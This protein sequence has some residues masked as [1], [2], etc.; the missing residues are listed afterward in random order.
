MNRKKNSNLLLGA[1]FACLCALGVS[2]CASLSEGECREADWY[3]IGLHDGQDGQPRSML[4]DHRKACAK[5]GIVPTTEA[6]YL[7]REVGLMDYCTPNTGF[8]Q[9][10]KGI[11]YRRV[12]PPDTEQ[13]FLEA[14][15]WGL[16][17]HKAEAA[18]DETR[19]N[20]ERREIELRKAGDDKPLRKKLYREIRLLEMELRIRSLELELLLAN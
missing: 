3:E 12:C 15:E 11:A 19:E 10:R 6:W 8:Q 16:E 20:L 13:E 14:H 1:S 7:G 5:H 2:G 17:I 18:I 9:G 4:D